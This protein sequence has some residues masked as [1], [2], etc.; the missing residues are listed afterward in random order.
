[1]SLPALLTRSLATAQY[2]NGRKAEFAR[3]RDTDR[4]GVDERPR[5]HVT[6]MRIVDPLCDPNWDHLVLSHPNHNFFHR[7]AWAKVLWKTYGHKPIYIRFCRERELVA[8][9]PLMEVASPFTGRRGVSLPFSDFCRPLVFTQWR[10]ESLMLRLLELG[11]KR[12][13]RYFELRGGRENFPASAAAS[14][15]YY[16]HKLDLSTGI[17]NLFARFKEPVR[18]AVRKAEK[19]GL[20]VEATNTR[21]AMLDFYRLHVRNRRRHGVPPQ[22]LSFFLNIHDEIMRADL[23]FV[24]VGKLGTRPV[25]AAIFF[26]SGEGALFKFGASDERTQEFRGNNLVMWEAIKRLVGKGLKTLHFGRTS[27]SN[28]GLRR[29][30]LSWGTEEEVIEYFRFALGRDMWVNSYRN[31]S[32]FH[33]QLFRK[34]PLAVNRLAGTLIYPHLD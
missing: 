13:W 24:I 33:N 4:F 21:E 16:G 19:S 17:E 32:E 34:L 20:S 31:A 5:P 7:A 3:G 28:D 27:V 29:F 25:A 12:K 8:L 6:E 18:R 10:Q 23:G 11:R 15:K 30:K 2:R 14:E 1:V 22:P 26:H 9:V